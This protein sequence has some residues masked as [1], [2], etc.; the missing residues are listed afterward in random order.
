MTP[1]GDVENY[2]WPC[3]DGPELNETQYTEQAIC[4]D[5]IGSGAAT[6]PHYA[7]PHPAQVC[8]GATRDCRPQYFT[9]TTAVTTRTQVAGPMDPDDT[10]EIEVSVSRD[11]VTVSDAEVYTTEGSSDGGDTGG[12]PGGGD[13]GTAGDMEI[14]IDDFDTET[15]V[16]TAAGTDYSYDDDDLFKIDDAGDWIVAFEN[17][18]CVGCTLIGE[19]YAPGALSEWN[20]LTDTIADPPPGIDDP[21]ASPGAVEGTLEAFDPAARTITVDGVAYP[22]DTDDFFKVNDFGE[23]IVKWESQLEVGLTLSADPYAADPA[24]VSEV[25]LTVP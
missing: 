19:P 15:N 1:G 24:E 17:A 11:G 20:L 6:S 9:D 16:T 10:L 18:L 7:Y 21:D 2:G 3:Y 12:D 5:L 23:W 22:Y 8:D 25:D 4:Q 14:V 13:P